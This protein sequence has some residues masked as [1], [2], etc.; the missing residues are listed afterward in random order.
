MSLVYQKLETITKSTRGL[1][2]L[3]KIEYL[4]PCSFHKNCVDLCEKSYRITQ[5]FPVHDILK[6]LLKLLL[7]H[8]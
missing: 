2:D 4:Q 5:Q 1:C 8:L 7:D 6:L 3:I